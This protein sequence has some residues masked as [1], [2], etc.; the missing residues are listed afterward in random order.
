MDKLKLT[1]K[2]KVIFEAAIKMAY[3]GGITDGANAVNGIVQLVQGS[4]NVSKIV[5]D[6]YYEPED[7]LEGADQQ[8]VQK[9]SARYREAG[10]GHDEF[11]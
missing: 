2:Q 6:E 1:A 8:P 9:A 4:K 5:M 11:S 3:A 10:D 7:A